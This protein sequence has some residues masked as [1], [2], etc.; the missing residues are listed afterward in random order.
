MMIIANHLCFITILICD[1][2]LDFGTDGRKVGCEAA[3]DARG[4]TGP[5]LGLGLASTN[6][7]QLVSSSNESLHFSGESPW[8]RGL[9]PEMLGITAK[10]GP[11]RSAG[12]R[13]TGCFDCIVHIW[14]QNSNNWEVE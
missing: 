6:I 12:G 10:L 7:T 13:Q 3:R 2:D 9:T 5:G 4:K 8:L 11:Q 14:Q 1:E